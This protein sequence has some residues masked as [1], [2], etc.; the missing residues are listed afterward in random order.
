[1]D[2]SQ[3]VGYLG[4]GWFKMASPLC[5]ASGAGC[6]LMLAVGWNNGHDGP[7]VLAGWLGLIHMVVDTEIPGPAREDKPH[8]TSTFQVSFGVTLTNVPLAKTSHVV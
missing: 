1:M 7:W 5:L 8:S 4:A 2:C 3:L 6:Q